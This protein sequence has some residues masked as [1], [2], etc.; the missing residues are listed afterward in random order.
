MVDAEGNCAQAGNNGRGGDSG[1]RSGEADGSVGAGYGVAERGDH[2]WLAAEDLADL[3]RNGV[4]GRF[5][6]RGQHGSQDG[7]GDECGR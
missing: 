4:R 6:Q 3:G 5:G 1:Q 2:A 7:N